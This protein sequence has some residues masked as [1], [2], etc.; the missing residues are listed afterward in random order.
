MY[1]RLV[2]A[3]AATV[4]IRYTAVRRQFGD[5]DAPI[6]VN[7]DILETQTLDYTMV[8]HGLSKLTSQVQ[9]RLLP[10]VAQSFAL[11]FTGFE[12]SMHPQLFILFA[13]RL[14]TE[15][16][17]QMAGGNFGL[18]ADLHAS[19]SGLKS[20]TSTYRNY[21]EALTHLAWQQTESNS[22][23]EHVEAMDSPCFPALYTSIRITVCHI[24]FNSDCSTN[25]NLGRGQVSAFSISH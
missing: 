17:K 18:L 9:Y 21:E 20:L 22:Q 6:Y 16:Q 1:A 3:R 5:K 13:E 14:Y 7:D 2:L 11:H 8:P 25:R 4:A 10:L 19:S 15:N 12:M 24:S 23:G